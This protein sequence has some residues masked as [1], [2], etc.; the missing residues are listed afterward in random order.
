VCYA[1]RNQTRR[2]ND[3]ALFQDAFCSAHCS[4]CPSPPS[5][6]RPH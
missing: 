3:F 2:A 1:P 6:R 4:L 5:R